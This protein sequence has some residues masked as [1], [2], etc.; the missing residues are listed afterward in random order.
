ML[1]AFRTSKPSEERIKEGSDLLAVAILQHLKS[2]HQT[3]SATTVMEIRHDVFN[4]IFRGRGRPNTKFGCILLEKNDF[5]RCSFFKECNDWDTYIDNP[6]DGTQV[7]FPIR[8]K[9]LVS[10]APQTHKLVEGKLVPVAC[11]FM[12]PSLYA[13]VTRGSDQIESLSSFGH[14]AHFTIDYFGYFLF[15]IFFFFLLL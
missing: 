4:Y 7:V 1:R 2:K 6:R 5:N 12:Q 13:L 14:C 8:T 10:L 9:A 3:A 11:N 15:P